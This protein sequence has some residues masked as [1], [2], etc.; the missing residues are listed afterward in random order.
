MPNGLVARVSS[1]SAGP[2]GTAEVETTQ[3]TLADVFWEYH[4]FIDNRPLYFPPKDSSAAQAAGGETQIRMFGSEV[5]GPGSLN[6]PLRPEYLSVVLRPESVFQGTWTTNLN[7]DKKLLDEDCCTIELTGGLSLSVTGEVN[8]NFSFPFTDF[9]G[10]VLF[11][12]VLSGSYGHGDSY[13]RDHE[14]QYPPVALHRCN[15]RNWRHSRDGLGRS[16]RG[17]RHH[18]K[19]FRN[20]HRTSD[21]AGHWRL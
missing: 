20:S 9:S 11:T 14:R 15:V 1:V 6:E 8:E 21:L 7:F 4:I 10:E 3:A 17:L 16:G 12:P 18:G 5:T 2:S 13:C 19:H